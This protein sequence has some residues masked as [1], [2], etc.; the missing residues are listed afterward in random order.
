MQPELYPYAFMTISAAFF[1][2]LIGSRRNFATT[3]FRLAQLW[4]TNTLLAGFHV[5]MY[6]ALEASLGPNRTYW[7]HWCLLVFFLVVLINTVTTL[8]WDDKT[9]FR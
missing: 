1:A 4:H 6:P 9:R 8:M 7:V 5:V 2:A 3:Y